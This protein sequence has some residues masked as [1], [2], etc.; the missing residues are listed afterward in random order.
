MTICKYN[1]H[2][3]RSIEK[4][5][6][7]W[8]I[9]VVAQRIKINCHTLFDTVL[10]INSTCKYN[11]YNNHARYLLY[12][13]CFWTLDEFG[14]YC[15][16]VWHLI[17]FESKKCFTEWERRFAT[18]C[19][20]FE[21]YKTTEPLIPYSSPCVTDYYHIFKAFY[22]LSGTR[23]NKTCGKFVRFSTRLVILLDFWKLNLNLFVF[24]CVYVQ[25]FASVLLCNF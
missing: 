2:Y 25:Y 21:F 11:K 1:F 18:W 14:N 9:V 5:V 23:E 20:S 22:E 8:I 13:Y 4:P 6:E 15:W 16:Q 19:I 3:H 12:H 10:S 17:S 7:F 24:F